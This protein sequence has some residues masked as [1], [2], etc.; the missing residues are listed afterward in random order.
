[1]FTS[2]ASART[3]TESKGHTSGFAGD[4]FVV[5]WL[6]A[7]SPSVNAWTTTGTPV[8]RGR[9]SSF[10]SIESVRESAEG[11]RGRVLTQS[12]QGHVLSLVVEK[13]GPSLRQ[14][15]ALPLDRLFQSL[16]E[17][18]PLRITKFVSNSARGQGQSVAIVQVPE[19]VLRKAP[20]GHGDDESSPSRCPPHAFDPLRL[21]RGSEGGDVIDP[22]CSAV[23][24]RGES[25]RPG[26]VLHVHP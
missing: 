9:P 18:D 17:R 16:L 3:K 2:C 1:M 5:R 24:H 14:V 11:G 21:A 23:V 22:P 8:A 13:V 10:L 6:P 26:G 7:G 15:V 12:P 4:P 20:V 25:D 19:E